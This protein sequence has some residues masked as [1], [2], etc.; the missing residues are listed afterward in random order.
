MESEE[1]ILSLNITNA[2]DSLIW[3]KEIKTLPKRNGCLPMIK[4]INSALLSSTNVSQ[5]RLTQDIKGA[6]A[7]NIA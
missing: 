3:L 4:M 6:L 1:K 5:L 7:I 2:S